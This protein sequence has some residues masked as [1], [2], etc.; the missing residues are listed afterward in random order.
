[1]GLRV[2]DSHTGNHHEDDFTPLETIRM[3]LNIIWEKIPFELEGEAFKP[4][5]MCKNAHN[6]FS[7]TR[8]PLY[9]SCAL[10]V[11]AFLS[12]STSCQLAYTT[13]AKLSSQRILG[14][15]LDEG[16]L[17]LMSKEDEIRFLEYVPRFRE[18]LV[19]IE[20]G[21]SL[22]EKHLME[23]MTSKHNVVLIEEIID[24]DVNDAVRKEL[25]ADSG[26]SG[27]IPLVTFHQTSHVGKDGT[28][29]ATDFRVC[30]SDN[31]FPPPWSTKKMLE[32]RARR[33]APTWFSDE[34]VDQGIDVEWKDD[35]Y[36]NVDEPEEIS[37]MIS[38][39]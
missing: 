11:R 31:E 3:F 23:L 26:N 13:L 19:Y 24:H 29:V 10:H 27:K 16:L 7:L 33:D 20:I 22:V 21:V 1:M 25:G 36:H 15:S 34:D 30:D 18:V 32:D 5:R 9:T 17:P 38:I 39:G 35:P 6:P 14:Q 2:A 37:D 12:F 4:K 28:I 8:L